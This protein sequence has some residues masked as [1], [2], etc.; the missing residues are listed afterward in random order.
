MRHNLLLKCLRHAVQRQKSKKSALIRVQTRTRMSEHNLR[1]CLTLAPRTAYPCPFLR[2]GN[3]MGYGPSDI[4]HHRPR[5]DQGIIHRIPGKPRGNGCN[6]LAVPDHAGVAARRKKNWGILI[7]RHPKE[8][9]ASSQRGSSVQIPAVHHRNAPASR[10]T[11]R[12]Q[13]WWYTH[14]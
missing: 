3:I 13:S 7:L 14:Y 8:P 6:N 10:R 9:R 11:A 12:R 1:Q 4:M 5:A 2:M